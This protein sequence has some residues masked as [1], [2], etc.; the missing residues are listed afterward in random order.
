MPASLCSEYVIREEYTIVLKKKSA[1]AQAKVFGSFCAENMG[2][3]VRVVWRPAFIRD[4]DYVYV[5]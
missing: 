4:S 3:G 2:E 1:V 5:S